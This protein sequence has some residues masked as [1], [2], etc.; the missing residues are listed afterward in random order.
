MPHRN[1]KNNDKQTDEWCQKHLID[2]KE[3]YERYQISKND[4][5]KVIEDIEII[6]L[7]NL[8]SQKKYIY[9]EKE[10]D[11]INPMDISYNKDSDERE[12]ISKND[13]VKL[14]GNIEDLKVGKLS[15]HKY[16]DNVGIESNKRNMVDMSD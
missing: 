13:E 5:E 14:S 6:T 2:D 4:E 16:V 7:Q 9:L 15:S 10:S 3:S 11:E 8:S 1:I 12:Q